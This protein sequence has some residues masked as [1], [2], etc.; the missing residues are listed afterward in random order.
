[1]FFN[2]SKYLYVYLFYVF[3][4]SLQIFSICSKS[5]QVN[6]YWEVVIKYGWPIILTPKTQGKA[7]L[8]K[9]KQKK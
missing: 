9:Q 7:K 5:P 1:M 6:L 4:W 8:T 3:S 2:C